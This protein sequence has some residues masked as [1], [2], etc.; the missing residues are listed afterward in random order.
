MLYYQPSL[1][2]KRQ[3]VVAIMISYTSL[4]FPC[5][6]YTCLFGLVIGF[7]THP[8]FLPGTM[9]FMALELLTVDE[10]A[11]DGKVR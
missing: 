3:D 1:N 8:P 4:F 7:C 11:W 5:L 6:S 10:D 9:P 2:V